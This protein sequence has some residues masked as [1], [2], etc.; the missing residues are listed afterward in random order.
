MNLLIL[1]LGTFVFVILIL[2]FIAA[3]TYYVPKNTFNGNP[4]CTYPLTNTGEQDNCDGGAGYCNSSGNK[5][6]MF[7]YSCTSLGC[8][9]S[10][11]LGICSS[12][13]DNVNFDLTNSYLT[14]SGTN[15]TCN[16]AGGYI[17]NGFICK[18]GDCS[19]TAMEFNCTKINNA[20]IILPQPKIKV[21]N[22]GINCSSFYGDN[23]F[24]Y[25]FNSDSSDMYLYCAK[26]CIPYC[27]SSKANVTACGVS[28]SDNCEGNCGIN[29]TNCINP[30]ETCNTNTWTCSIA[31]SL[32]SAKWKNATGSEILN[33]EVNEQVNLSVTGTAMTGKI[34][35][36]TVYNSTDGAVWSILKTSDN[37]NFDFTNWIAIDGTFYFNATISSANQKIKSGVIQIGTC[38][39]FCTPPGKTETSCS[40]LQLAVR[41]CVEYTSS[42]SGTKCYNWSLWDIDDCDIG[43]MCWQGV[44][45]T[46]DKPVA[47]S[48]FD[49]KTRSE[50]EDYDEDVCKDNVNQFLFNN[51]GYTTMPPNGFCDTGFPITSDPIYDS[52]DGYC[53]SFA[54][55]C[56][57]KWEGDEDTGNCTV[58]YE[59]KSTCD[60]NAYKGNCTITAS[61]QDKCDTTGYKIYTTKA[62]WKWITASPTS[63]D[64]AANL[65]ASCSNNTVSYKCVSTAKLS[66]FDLSGLVSAVFLIIF[67]YLFLSIKKKN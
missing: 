40:G 12:L 46:P 8:G 67:V 13:P 55:N 41:N 11:D 18:E 60:H 24:V 58:F 26:V 19:K 20:K 22:Y 23:Y 5:G 39:N 1:N 51:S 30:G 15:E 25:G 9:F 42:P 59:E 56:E 61:V 3:V 6:A 7:G 21:V 48:C 16:I 57:C 33:A 53:D 32:T 14:A 17:A 63:V 35:N 2:S 66:F 50:C 28:I 64:L 47:G 44:C 27:N 54:E 52:I 65:S 38:D 62:V 37:D 4:A 29:G 49:Y 43:K 31:T 36:Y 10:D 45:I 34:I